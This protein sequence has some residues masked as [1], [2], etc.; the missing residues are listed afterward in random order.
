MGSDS[1]SERTKKIISEAIKCTL[2]DLEEATSKGIFFTLKV[3][4]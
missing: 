4:D 2:E 3:K 1:L